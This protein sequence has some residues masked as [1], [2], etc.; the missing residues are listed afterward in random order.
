MMV[1]KVLII[2]TANKTIMVMVMSNLFH[3]YRKSN[4]KSKIK[5]GVLD[6]VTQCMYGCVLTPLS[7]HNK[8]YILLDQTEA[9]VFA[10]GCFIQ[11]VALPMISDS[12][13]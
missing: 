10:F 13:E 3:N 7:N 11:R 6:Q 9:E 2:V 4:S 1:V 5:N 12:D 8:N